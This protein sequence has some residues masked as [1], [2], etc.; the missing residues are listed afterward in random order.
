MQM[1]SFSAWSLLRHESTMK[2]VS[3]IARSLT[4]DK[5]PMFIM[6]K[7]CSGAVLSVDVWLNVIFGCKLT[8]CSP[9]TPRFGPIGFMFALFIVFWA[10]SGFGAPG[11]MV[12]AERPD[13]V[14]QPGEKIVWKVQM[15]GAR[16]A[17][18][19]QVSYVLKQGGATVIG[20]G[21]TDFKDG[22]AMI[23][24]SI[25]EPGTILADITATNLAGAG[26]HALAGAA[27]APEKIPVSS[28]C[29]ADFDA[30]WQAKLDELARV[31]ENPVLVSEAADKAG[32]E[33]WKITMD[34]IRNTH[35]Q[36]Q[37]ARPVSGKRFPAM[38][39]VQ[40]AGVYRLEK[41][42]AT[43][44][45]AEGWLVLDI[46]AHDLPIDEP[47]SFYDDLSKDAL[48]NYAAIGNDDREHSYFLRMYLAC[49]RAAEYLSQRPDWDGRTL[50]VAGT[51]QGGLQSFVTAGLNHK[52]TTLMALVPAGCDDTGDQVG[53]TPGWPNWMANVGIHDPKKVRETARY[54]DGVSFAARVKCPALIGLGLVDVTSPPS[55][56]F[57]A[58]NQ[59][60][61]PKEVVIM[62][63]ANHHGDNKTHAPFQKRSAAWQA[64]LLNHQPVP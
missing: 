43:D 60:Q 14:Y 63:D 57:A 12:T 24:T 25:N 54:F 21:V 9:I 55:G 40:W 11:L 4:F 38:L 41:T 27:V 34:N 33:Y 18:I 44:R 52:I 35:I 13:A 47:K 39:I 23:E 46:S 42:W 59:L 7:R 17:S 36:G 61:G 28:P 30:F 64:A 56:V 22:V 8:G 37:L 31:P 50:V 10:V 48:Y 19:K 2:K 20:R 16:D 15:R 45:A 58:I 6:I 3:G 49:Y 26:L 53:R 51:S 1:N 29:P 62:P 32:V 5:A